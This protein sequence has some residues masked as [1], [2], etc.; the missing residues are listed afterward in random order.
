MSNKINKQHQAKHIPEQPILAFLNT[1][2]VGCLFPG[3]DNSVMSVM[4]SWVN[5]KLAKAK[6][7]SL[8]K[9]GKVEGCACGCRGD[10][11]LINK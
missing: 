10:F 2:P 9:Q 8:I 1:V 3:Y 7:K 11:R 5:E 6:M 4:P